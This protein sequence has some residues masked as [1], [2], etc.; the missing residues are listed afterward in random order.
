MSSLM[1]SSVVIARPTEQVFSYISDFENMPEW[2]HDV[3][4]C[5]KTTGG[6]AGPGTTYEIGQVRM[7]RAYPSTVRLVEFDPNRRISAE[8]KVGPLDLRLDFVV[9]PVEQGTQVT[10]NGIGELRGFLKLLTPIGARQGR[11][12]WDRRLASL[13]ETMES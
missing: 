10:V 5:R 4:Y 1:T 13:K 3:A 11:R 7:G 12:I 9:E 6:P 2:A 8:A